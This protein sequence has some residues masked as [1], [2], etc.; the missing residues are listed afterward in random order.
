MILFVSDIH[1]GSGDR[2]AERAEE[3]DLTAFLRA[4]GDTCEHLYLLGDVYDAYI[5]YASLIPKGLARFQ[6]L[7][8]EWT[9]SGR[10]VTY[11]VGNHDPWHLSY[12]EDELGV[13]VEEEP[14]V[15]SHYGHDIYLAHGDGIEGAA[16]ETL[17]TIIRHPIPTW[18]YRTIFPA[19]LGFRLARWWSVTFGRDQ[20]R[21]SLVEALESHAREV[22]QTTD[23]GFVLMGHSHQ[24]ACHKW[25]EGT[26]INTGSWRHER[27]Y[28]LLDERGLQ[29]LRWKGSPQVA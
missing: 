15:V 22:L 26:Y 20:I 12:Y 7:L 2:A 9:D 1:F 14:F 23:A 28:A 10:T 16:G 29:L 21:P 8:G 3:R 19:D 25:P 17:K 11:L 13:C 18:L 5:E 6:G 27:T 24:S 4:H